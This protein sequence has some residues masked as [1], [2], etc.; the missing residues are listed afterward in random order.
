MGL[1]IEESERADQSSSAQHKTSLE[2][3]GGDAR[4]QRQQQRQRRLRGHSVP[5]GTGVKES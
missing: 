3:T 2:S 5:W 4:Q 1:W